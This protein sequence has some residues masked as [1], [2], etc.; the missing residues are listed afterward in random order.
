MIVART[1][2]QRANRIQIPTEGPSQQNRN[3]RYLQDTSEWNQATSLLCAASEQNEFEICKIP[4]RTGTQ[5]MSILIHHTHLP[6]SNLDL[7][8]AWRQQHRNS[9]NP[10]EICRTLLYFRRTF[11][12]LKPKE[13]PRFVQK[14]QHK[15]WKSANRAELEPEWCYE[16]Y[17]NPNSKILFLD[18]SNPNFKSGESPKLTRKKGRNA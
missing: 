9:D 18:Y 5:K 3:R 12:R 2:T 8:S 1:T 4:S 16:K 6:R 7:T 14:R 10:R 17:P 13:S 15:G 11:E